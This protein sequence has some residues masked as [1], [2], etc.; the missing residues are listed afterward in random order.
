SIDY[1]KLCYNIFN[2]DYGKIVNME[3]IA[4]QSFDEMQAYIL[5]QEKTD[6][7]LKEAG[8]AIEKA[9]A[10]FAAKYNVTLV[11]ESSELGNKMEEAASLQ[12]Y[13]NQLYLIFFKVNWQ[14][15]MLLRA[16]EAKKLNEIEQTRNA[17]ISYINEGLA[18]LD[19]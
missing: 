17:M 15:A 10:E 3:E 12:K 18:I 7:K 11:N 16:M 9:T 5:L 4:E 1:I 13:S 2:D 14:D 6:E 19:T 8:D